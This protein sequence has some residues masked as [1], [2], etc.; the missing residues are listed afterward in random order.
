MSAQFKIKAA[1]PAS[2]VRLERELGLPRFIAATLVARGIDNPAAVHRF[3]APSLER[4]WLDP[5]T[6]PRLS[7]VAD[8]L[9][10]AVKRGDHILVFGDFDLDGISATTV[11]TRGLRALGAQATP[12]IPLRFEEGYALSQ[13]AITRACSFGPDFI[14]TVDCG[15]ACKAE[16]A[17]VVEAGLGLAITD[18]HEPVDLVPEGVPVADPK[19]DANCPSSILAGVGVA[20]FL[21]AALNGKLE[22]MSGKRM[23]MRQV[24]DLVA[25]G[26]LADMVSLTGQNRILV[27]NGL[28]K[29][30]EAKRPGLAELKG[31]SGFSPVAALG[32]GQVVFNLAPRINAAGRL[33]SPTLAHD[34]LLTPSHDEAAKLAQTLTSLNDE[35]RSEED[36][37]YKEALEQA[38]A[39]PKRLGFVLYGKDWH[40][41]VIG[42]VASRIV[43]VYYRPVLILCSDGE[44]LKGSG[45]SVP[46][47]DLHAGLTRCADMLL[48]FGG[49]RQAAGLRIAPGR[50]D[51]LR[52]R[53]DA[54]IREELGEAPLT[55]SLKIDAEMPFSQASDF[56]VLKG[57]ELL[58]PFGIGNPEPIFASLPL[59][60]KKRKAFGHSREHISLEVTEEGSG[61]TLQAKAWRQA[62]QIPESIQ[63]QR[64][65]LA[66][67]PG[68]NAYNGIASVELRVRDWEVL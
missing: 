62:D 59:R 48:G 19:C 2:V 34:M 9:E 47:F 26:T 58:Q 45:R 56:T 40:Q 17:A 12:F 60:V 13:A 4:D 20:F 28:L 21:M 8:A 39:N 37:I 42:I 36:R 35:R 38:E 63:G 15:I 43:E 46:E 29:I 22:A 25:L 7:D 49:H 11:L 14:V 55:P 10:A 3:L 44:S 31:A 6:I 51:E 65:R 61:I 33:G 16:A 52:E 5:Y 64:I 67:T 24:L 32:A 1:D 66:Y 18:H 27:K 41:G 57:L 30:A 53:F 68:I 23:D 50:L 54:V